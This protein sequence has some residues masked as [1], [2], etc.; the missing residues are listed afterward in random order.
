MIRT[1]NAAE[2]LPHS[3]ELVLMPDNAQLTQQ[4]MVLALRVHIWFNT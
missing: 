4:C 3:T 1:R 2:I